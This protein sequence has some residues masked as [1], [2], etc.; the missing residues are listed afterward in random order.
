MSS[1]R[2]QKPHFMSPGIH[3]LSLIVLGARSQAPPPR[4]GDK[5]ARYMGGWRG[6]ERQV[7]DATITLV[8]RLSTIK[9][10]DAIDITVEAPRST[11]AQIRVVDTHKLPDGK[12]VDGSAQ[13]AQEDRLE[14]VESAAT[15]REIL[16][17]INETG[18]M[19]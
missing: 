5:R 18:D 12:A 3:T 19:V 8:H 11:P 15:S 10:A 6:V 9:D 7:V 17:K 14:M 4:R 16:E 1:R 2:S 13:F